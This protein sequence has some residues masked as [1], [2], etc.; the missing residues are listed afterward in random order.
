ME[1]FLQRM[2]SIS[3]GHPVKNPLPRSI[4]SEK[5]LQLRHASMYSDPDSQSTYTSVIPPPPSRTQ[6]KKVSTSVPHDV[7][8][9]RVAAAERQDSTSPVISPHQSPPTSPVTWRKHSK[10]HPSGGNTGLKQGLGFLW[11]S[12]AGS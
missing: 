1:P 2:F 4:V 7:I 8:G 5:K 12:T 6:V 3:N 9:Q 10:Q 11:K